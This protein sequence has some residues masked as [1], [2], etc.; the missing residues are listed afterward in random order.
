MFIAWYLKQIQNEKKET[1]EWNRYIYSGRQVQIEKRVF[2][3]FHYFVFSVLFFIFLF[4]SISLCLYSYLLNLILF[5]AFIFLVILSCWHCRTN[6]WISF[7][8]K[9]SL[10]CTTSIEVIFFYLSNHEK[11]IFGRTVTDGVG[12][13]EN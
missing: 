1:I 10:R 4:P 3:I 8:Q 7:I 12:K 6:V 11:C 13:L 9:Y 5:S 2:I